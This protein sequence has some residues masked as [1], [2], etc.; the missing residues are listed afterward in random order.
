M[1]HKDCLS[2][3]YISISITIQYKVIRI[4]DYLQHS[5]LEGASEAQHLFL[6]ANPVAALPGPTA[7]SEEHSSGQ[8]L[9]ISWLTCTSTGPKDRASLVQSLQHIEVRKHWFESSKSDVI[10]P[11]NAYNLVTGQSSKL[12]AFTFCQM[13]LKC[14]G[15][16]IQ[17][18]TQYMPQLHLKQAIKTSWLSYY[19]SCTW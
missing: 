1:D 6:K 12:S 13:Y 2:V 19:T 7:W 11:T 8:S 17:N 9:S 3:F 15:L 18:S 4:V 10:H 14:R 16:E 5:R